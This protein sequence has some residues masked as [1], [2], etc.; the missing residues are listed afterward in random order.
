MGKILHIK[1]GEQ[2]SLQY[3]Q[4]KDETIMVLAGRLRFEHGEADQP[5][6]AVELGPNE[7][8]SYPPRLRHRD[9]AR[10]YRRGRG[11]DARARRCRATGRSLRPHRHVNALAG[12]P[13]PGH[14]DRRGNADVFSISALLSALTFG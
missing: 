13:L 5:L 6:G 14:A 1:A 8:V 11:I 10:R 4:R 9:R 3:H 7:A 12:S 2:L